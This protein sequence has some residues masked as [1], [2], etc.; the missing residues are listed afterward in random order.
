[1]SIIK[2]KYIQ[3]SNGHLNLFFRPKGHK[4]TIQGLDGVFV[5]ELDRYVVQW[6]GSLDHDSGYMAY[7][8]SKIDKAL[9]YFE[10]YES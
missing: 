8:S 3:G 2:S 5:Q 6:E 10:E 9:Q 4:F 7:E 1:M